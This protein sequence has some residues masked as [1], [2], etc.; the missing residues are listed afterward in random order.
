M[1][2]RPAPLASG[3]VHERLYPQLLRGSG[4]HWFPAIL[5]V[6]LGFAMFFTLTPLIRQALLS[7]GWAL[8]GGD[9]PYEDYLQAG[10][11]F[12]MPI[13]ML[14][15]NLGSA[16]LIPIS[17]AL[18]ILLHRRP[19]RQLLSVT[20]Q[21][22]WRYLIIC[23]GIAALILGTT[24]VIA[25]VTAPPT[26]DGAEPYLWWFLVIIVLTSPLQAAAEEVFF[27]GYLTQALGSLH[28]APWFG[29]LAPAILFALLHGTQ[30]LPLFLNRLAFGLL[31]GLLVLATGGLEAGIAAHVVNN[32]LAYT[33]AV[34]TGTVTEIREVSTT[35]WTTAATG[36]AAFL[37][38][39]LAAGLLARHLNLAT[40]DAGESSQGRLRS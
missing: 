2:D 4:N 22:R 20:S 37:A 17:A 10:F 25:S 34:L 29:V 30:N 15:A 8:S 26:P 32:V 23:L 35:D 24:Q 5:G 31:A 36:I 27:R 11:R 12:E 21:I 1:S 38:F 14:A 40:R 9:T 39:A 7:L 33:A 18:V 19:A 3:T 28:A 16:A 13:G 6:A